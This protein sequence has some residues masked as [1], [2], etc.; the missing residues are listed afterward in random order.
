MTTQANAFF[1]VK[2]WHEQPY[3]ELADGVKFTRAQ[4]TYTYTG[5]MQGESTV[6]YLM[7]YN[8][9]GQVHFVGI[10]HFTGSLA[11][12]SG[13]FVLR[14]E[15]MDRDGG[16]YSDYII[17]PG[18]ATGNLSAVSGKGSMVLKGEADQY[19]FSIDYEFA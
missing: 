18:S 3:Q 16:V 4:V 12:R 17:L 9:K 1:S 15:G 19:P 6:E 13:S 8:G 10:E 7:F 2:S 14:H 5:D 11:G